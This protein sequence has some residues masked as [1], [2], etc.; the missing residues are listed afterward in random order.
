M[1]D[2]LIDAVQKYSALLIDGDI[3]FDDNI[4]CDSVVYDDEPTWNSVNA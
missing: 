3:N 4:W 2:Q 1:T